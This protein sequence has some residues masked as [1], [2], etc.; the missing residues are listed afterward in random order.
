MIEIAAVLSLIVHHWADFWII[1]TLLLLN[2]GVGFW[3]EHE[4]DNAIELLKRRLAPKAQVSPDG[5]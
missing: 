4:A 2:A 1:F 3:Q 5:K